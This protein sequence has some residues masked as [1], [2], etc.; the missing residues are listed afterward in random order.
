[1]TDVVRRSF[2]GARGGE[3]GHQPHQSVTDDVAVRRPFGGKSAPV[4]TF[5]F[6]F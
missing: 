4:F 3:L 1:M 2:C 5:K 6:G